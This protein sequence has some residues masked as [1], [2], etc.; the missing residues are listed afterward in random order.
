MSHH[1]WDEHVGNHPEIIH[2]EVDIDANP[3]KAALYGVMAVPTVLKLNDKNEVVNTH[4]G[5]YNK[6]ALERL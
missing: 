6:D 5:S 1:F 2:E 4:V 3:D